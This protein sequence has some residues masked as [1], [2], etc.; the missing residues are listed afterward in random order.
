MKKKTQIIYKEKTIEEI[1]ELLNLQV[2]N[3]FTY[4]YKGTTPRS[5]ANYKEI[6]WEIK[7][8]VIDQIIDKINTIEKEFWIRTFKVIKIEKD[9]QR[10][11]KLSIDNP[12]IIYVETIIVEDLE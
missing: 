1:D 2:G 3:S 9:Y 5:E 6:H 12:E 11:H 4:N 8:E 10:S 7:P